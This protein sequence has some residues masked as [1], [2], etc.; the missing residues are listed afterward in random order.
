[1][2]AAAPGLVVSPPPQIMGNQWQ[3]TVPLSGN[4]QDFSGWYNKRFFASNSPPHEFHPR[5]T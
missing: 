5:P 1:M 2:A 4:A 3:V